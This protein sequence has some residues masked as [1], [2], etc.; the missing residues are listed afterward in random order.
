MLS[1]RPRQPT[2]SPPIPYAS[3]GQ[4]QIFLA[5]D[6]ASIAPAAELDQIADSIIEAL[7]QATPIDPA[8]PIRYPGEQTLKLREENITLGV[9]VDKDIW[10]NLQT[11]T[12]FLKKAVIS[13]RSEE[14]LHFALPLRAI[15]L[16]P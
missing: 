8:T 15:P 10:Q 11:F 3:S 7:H 9:P 1:R 16:P 6:P 4:S 14:S 13:E 5:I 12:S 2:C